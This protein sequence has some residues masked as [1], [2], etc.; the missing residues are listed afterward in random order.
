MAIKGI[1][2]TN[3]GQNSE[4]FRIQADEFLSKAKTFPDLELIEVKNQNVLSYIKNNTPD[5]CLFWD[6]DIYLAKRIETKGI[7]VFNNPKTIYLCDDKALSAA[8]LDK[9]NIAQPRFFVFPLHYFGNIIEYYD[10]YKEELLALKFPLVIKERFGSFGDQVYLAHNEEELKKIIEKH[11]TKPLMAQAFVNGEKGTDYRV[12]VVGN[13]VMFTVKRVNE[14]DFRSNINQGGKASLV[15]ASHEIE[16]LA[17]EATKA[18]Y[19]DFAG[20]DIMLNALGKP[21]VIEVNS[22]MRTVA[23]NKVSDVD[24]TI[25]I[26][27][28]IIKNV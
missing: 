24:L 18:V 26:L 17:L 3:I 15:S 11:G 20:V 12:N 19:G 16:N 8:V 14:K 27:D 7:K 9:A 6:K 13:K 22:N 21:L 5:F 2:V 4:K 23:V 10:A 1:F 28:Y 25:A